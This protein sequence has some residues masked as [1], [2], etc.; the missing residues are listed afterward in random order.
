[1]RSN[2][3]FTIAELTVVLVII[4]I[5]TML[6]MNVEQLIYTANVKSDFSKINKFEIALNQYYLLNHNP[7]ERIS[8]TNPEINVTVFVERELLTVKDLET[9]TGDGNWILTYGYLPHLDTSG[10]WWSYAG[11]YPPMKISL[12]GNS[13]SPGFAC[14]VE[15]ALDDGDLLNG[16]GRL[17][18]SSPHVNFTSA[19][20]DNCY[21]IS[22]EIYN[23]V[24]YAIV[25]YSPPPS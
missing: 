19:E 10:K 14:A 11:I 17:L 8:S 24:H 3:G 25:I 5:I 20:Y 7:P 23:Q 13:M 6:L 2:K 1:M 22:R 16:K 9:R 21:T 18:S 12:Q 4:G 15:K